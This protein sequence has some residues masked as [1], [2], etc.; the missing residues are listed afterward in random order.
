MQISIARSPSSSSELR[1]YLSLNFRT[2]GTGAPI[3]VALLDT[4][5][6][7]GDRSP[8]NEE[9]GGLRVCRPPDARQFLLP[10]DPGALLVPAGREIPEMTSSVF[11]VWQSIHRTLPGFGRYNG[12]R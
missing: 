6:R 12:D 5:I 3:R 1:G 11:V 9:A 4:T 7:S 8:N 10:V 2:F